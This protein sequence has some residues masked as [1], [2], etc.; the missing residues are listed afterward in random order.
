MHGGV[1]S[2]Y[3]WRA[4]RQIANDHPPSSAWALGKR[5]GG[6]SGDVGLRTEP[7]G[8]SSTTTSQHRRRC[9]TVVGERAHQRELAELRLL[10]ERQR[11]VVVNE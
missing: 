11:F 7:R 9:R 1:P 10:P 3:G 5:E 2:M 4:H 8:N 6:E